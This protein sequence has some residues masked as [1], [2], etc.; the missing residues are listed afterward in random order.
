MTPQPSTDPTI[1]IRVVPRAPP[2]SRPGMMALA[3]RPTSV[4]KPTHSK[5]SWAACWRIRVI[6]GFAIRGTG[7]NGAYSRVIVIVCCQP[8]PVTVSTGHH[9]ALEVWEFCENKKPAKTRPQPCSGS[10]PAK[11]GEGVVADSTPQTAYC[12]RYCWQ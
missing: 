8:V 12:C 6:W 5:T 4:P 3:A 10:S 9:L 7:D 1:P 11:G 2:G